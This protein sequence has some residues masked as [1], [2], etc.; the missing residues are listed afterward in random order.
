MMRADAHVHLF[1]DGFLGRYGRPSSGGD[2]RVIYDSLRH[3]HNIGA[4]LVVGYEGLPFCRGNNDYL[5]EVAPQCPWAKCVAFIPVNAPAVPHTA[6]A[7][8]SVFLESIEDAQRFAAWPT[9]L[10]QALIDRRAIV[11]LNAGPDALAAAAGTIRRLAGCSVLISHLGEPGVFARRPSERELAARLQPIISLA[12]ERHVGVKVSGFY[13]MSDP[14]Y[15][16]PHEHVD[17]VLTHI[18]DAFGMERIYW[19]SDFSPALDFVSFEQTLQVLAGRSWSATEID[20]VMG[21]NL[22]RLFGTLG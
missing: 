6:F 19:G 3:E 1:R 8:I 12:A 15:A 5:L 22:V 20:A 4:A 16:F 2:D 7:G 10:M 21:G 13:A 9:D 14:P 18:A 17:P 11:S